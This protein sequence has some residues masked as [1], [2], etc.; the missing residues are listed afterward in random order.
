MKIDSSMFTV[1]LLPTVPLFR[2][3][4]RFTGLVLFILCAPAALAQVGTTKRLS[5]DSGGVEGNKKSWILSPSSHGARKLAS[6]RFVVFDSE[7]TNFAVQDQNGQPDV[8]LRDLVTGSVD[9]ISVGPDG[10]EGNSASYVS[11][12]SADGNRVAFWSYAS[13]FSPLDQNAESDIFVRDRV[14]GTTTLVSARPDGY[15]GNGVSLSPVISGDGNVVAFLSVSTDLVSGDTNGTHDVFVRDLQAGQTERVNVG[16]DGRQ[17]LCQSGGLSISLNGRFV[18][19]VSCSRLTP[20][21]IHGIY[22][23]FMRDRETGTLEVVSKSTEGLAANNHCNRPSISDDGRYVCFESGATNL[24]DGDING[25]SDIFVRDRQLGTTVRVSRTYD[26]SPANGDCWSGFLSGDS[27]RVVFASDASNLVAGDTNGHSDLFVTDLL[28]SRTWLVPF[29][30][31]GAQLPV[32]T[33]YGQLSVEGRY[34]LI[35]SPSGALVEGDT[36]GVMDVFLHDTIRAEF[37][38]TPSPGQPGNFAVFSAIGETGYLALVLLSCSGTDGFGLPGDGRTVPLSFDACTALGLS[39]SPFLSATIGSTG[40]A[41]TPSMQFPHLPVGFI[42]Y[43]S[44]VTIDQSVP[45]FVTVTGPGSV[46][47]Q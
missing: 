13:N 47:V 4:V 11:S 20:D 46:V 29:D 17:D 36:N 22:L 44:A 24:V 38:G 1:S 42:F 40:I 41:R 23:V 3:T 30:S 2:G 5:T 9:R 34:L 15:S 19:F 7:A 39:L 33:L 14:L 18:A 32:D 21:A 31:Q 35:E 26:G 12:I 10:S 37:E 43:W 27:S 16:V 28:S 6:A 25:R 8:F 45:R